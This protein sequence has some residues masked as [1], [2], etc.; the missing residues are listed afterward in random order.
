MKNIKRIMEIQPSRENI[1]E[2]NIEKATKN[3]SSTMDILLNMLTNNNGNE[4]TNHNNAG[5]NNND[6]SSN[7]N[8]TTPHKNTVSNAEKEN[9][10]DTINK[11]K[12]DTVKDIKPESDKKNN[13]LNSEDNATI[14]NQVNGM[15]QQLYEEEALKKYTSY[16][17]NHN[18][19][20][21]MIDLN[22]KDE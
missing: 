16:L 20:S 18:K 13:T 19:L 14:K 17:E 7:N 8:A 22:L 12:A 10:L 11:E 6:N 15:Y 5:S 4:N 2:K 1:R 3:V 21:T 9:I